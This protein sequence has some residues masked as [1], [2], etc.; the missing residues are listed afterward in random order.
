LTAASTAG[1]DDRGVGAVRAL[2]AWLPAWS[3]PAVAALTTLGTARLLLPVAGI[4]YLTTNRRD[5]AFVLGT[6]LVGLALTL[7]LKAWFALPRPPADLQF[8]IASGYGFPSG[9]ALDATVTWGALAIALERVSTRR[10]RAWVAGA[11]V[12]VVAFSRVALGVHY[13]VDVVAGIAIGLVVLA[14]ASRW[15]R[16]D[17]LVLFGLAT[18]IALA[19]VGVTGASV[20]AVALLGAA[21]G[22]VAAWPAVDPAHEG[23]GCW[24]LA[25]LGVGGV[26]LLA[27]FAAVDPIAA[28]AFGGAALAMAAL[29]LG[30]RWLGLGPVEASTRS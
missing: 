1:F 24:Q 19:A 28:V 3:L 21:V 9:H 7:A 8:V 25:A 4:A 20:D 2:H 26:T 27:A 22:G 29:L 23:W 12:A 17:P 10:R 15:G 11:V 18:P 16:R 14:V 13:L 6:V 30:P 5:G